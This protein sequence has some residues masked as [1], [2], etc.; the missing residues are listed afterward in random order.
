MKM[1]QYVRTD[2]KFK[3]CMLTCLRRGCRFSDV[4]N[5]FAATLQDSDVEC[6]SLMWCL[7]SLLVKNINHLAKLVFLPIL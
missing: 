3:N 2:T 7:H 1:K 6:Y 5:N 4:K